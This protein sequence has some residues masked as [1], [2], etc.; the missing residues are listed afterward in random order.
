MLTHN[1]YLENGV[2]KRT[3][4]LTYTNFSKKNILC[5]HFL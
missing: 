5:Q 4:C 2:H 1:T 3:Y